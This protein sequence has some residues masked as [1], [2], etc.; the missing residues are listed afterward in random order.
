M[1]LAMISNLSKCQR[2]R[3]TAQQEQKYM[4]NKEIVEKRKRKVHETV[5]KSNIAET[6]QHKQR[7]F[8]SVILMECAISP[9]PGKVSKK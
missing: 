9:L 6:T 3:E 4:T 7:R 2:T 8:G 1:P 5:R